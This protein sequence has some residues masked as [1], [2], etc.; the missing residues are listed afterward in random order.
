[1]HGSG[2]RAG[3]VVAA[4]IALV[5][6]AGLAFNAGAQDQP[7]PPPPP[8]PAA[9]LPPISVPAPAPVALPPVTGPGIN[10]APW[11]S[12]FTELLPPPAGPALADTPKL[13]A[14]FWAIGQEHLSHSGANFSQ[15]QLA[16]AYD[17]RYP[18]GPF[19]FGA[20]P[21]FD[22]MFLSGPTPPGPDLP[23]QAYAL[24]VAL[25]GEFRVDPRFA[26]QAQLQPGIYT[27]FDHVSGNSFRVPA[28]LTGAFAISN[29]IIVVGGVMYTAQPSLA[30]LP[31][32]GVVWTPAPPWRLQLMF[33]Q[34]RAIYHVED[35]L[36][37]YGVLGLQGETYSVRV[38]GGSDLFQ[39]RDV[40]FGFGAEWATP[41][42][43]HLY[44]E[45]GLAFWRRIDLSNEGG[46]DV[47]P[48]L[49]IRVGGRF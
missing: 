13:T 32:V 3:G 47:N 10:P 37:I 22:V 5:L 42:R 19:T 1:M 29:E 28:Q 15:S 24:S 35:G 38:D 12:P 25:E 49:Y 14:D 20:R 11:L 2:G 46:V 40:R 7:P 31:V 9:T 8:P 16:L 4:L 48:G 45:A 36:N 17:F 39:Y 6:L 43:L 41:V 30:V 27:D 33:P 23:P 34:T 18:I 26:I 21:E 44:L